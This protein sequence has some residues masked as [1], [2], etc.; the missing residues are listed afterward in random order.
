VRVVS[1]VPAATEILC[2]IRGR[3]MLV[4]RSHE[5]D[6]PPGL[7]GTPVLSGPTVAALDPSSI[8]AAVRRAMDDRSPLYALDAPQLRTLRP[9][10]ILTQDLCRVCSIDMQTV[11][12]VAASMSP[13]PRVLSLDPH[14][15]EDVLDDILR[16]GEV[17]GLQRSAQ[18][19][20]SSLRERMFRAMDHVTPLVDGPGVAVLEWTD[21]I[22]VAGHWTPQLVERAGGRHPLNPTIAAADAG[23]AMGPMQAARR[24]GKS[25]TVPARALASSRPDF[26]IICPCGRTLKQAREDVAT[27]AREPWWPDLPAVRSGRVALVDGTQMFTRP[28]P[29]LIDALEWLVGWLNDRPEL[30]PPEFPWTTFSSNPST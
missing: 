20:V 22:Y 30:M 24:A 14:T 17:V 18:S 21:P 27:L 15:I 9:D 2:A 8:D 1:L 12:Q 5:C 6:F 3:R 29:R 28:G 7:E 23:A 19:F 26:L 10:V 16:V 11:R 25:V 13:P 4:G